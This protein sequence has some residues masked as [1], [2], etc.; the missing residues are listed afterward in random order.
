MAKRTRTTKPRVAEQDQILPPRISPSP[1]NGDTFID[2]QDSAPMEDPAISDGNE[3]VEAE[4]NG[5]KDITLDTNISLTPLKSSGRVSY[6]RY[7][8]EDKSDVYFLVHNRA[9]TASDASLKTGIPLST[10]RGWL[11]EDEVET[12]YAFTKEKSRSGRRPDIPKL[13]DEQ[14]KFLINEIDNDISIT[15][16]ELT[17]KLT[18][19]YNDLK[20]S[21]SG[22][23][24]F[25]KE[26]CYLALQLLKPHSGEKI[27]PQVS[28]QRSKWVS[29]LPAVLNP[30]NNCVFVGEATFTVSLMRSIRWAKTG[31]ES[32]GKL[33]A[34]KTTTTTVIG[35]ISGK[36]PL[37]FEVK[38]KRPAPSSTKRRRLTDGS[39]VV[40]GGSAS[41]Y[42]NFVQSLIE[43]LKADG[44]YEGSYILLEN[45]PLEN[46]RNIEAVIESNKFNCLFLPQ[47]SSDF[48][49][50]E[51]FWPIVRSHIKRTRLEDNETMEQRIQEG[52]NRVSS[53][54]YSKI[55]SWVSK[56]MAK[57]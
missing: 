33:P 5:G 8:P 22:V 28:K 14:T 56:S 41:H 1:E 44:Q 48:N 20:V 45:V 36:G 16:T 17:D 15:I 55:C 43:K 21:K 53:Q 39:I 46:Q 13:T 40:D 54:E 7:T 4:V 38:Y 51:D 3:Q 34:F 50:I 26:Y 10:V 24:K 47:Q 19:S 37:N 11:K 57:A 49:A 2:A 52:A 35:A 6:R 18:N 27:S 32:P 23:S 9:M 25:V 29:E 42:L 31:N 12:D 30:I